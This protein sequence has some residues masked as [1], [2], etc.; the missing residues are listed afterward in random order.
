VGCHPTG[1][2][3]LDPAYTAVLAAAVTVSAAKANRFALLILGVTGAVLSRSWV[4]LPAAIGAALAVQIAFPGRFSRRLES[5]VRPVVGTLAIQS[6]LRWPSVGFHGLTALITG[7][8]VGLVLVTA[9]AGTERRARRLLVGA[10]AAV[11]LLAGVFSALVGL[12]AMMAKT[13]VDNGIAQARKALSA[14]SSGDSSVGSAELAAS[15]GDLRSAHA[16][17]SSWWTLGGLLVPG[18]AQQRRAMVDATASA[19]ALTRAA[20][21]EA[22]SL[23]Y[24]QLRFRHGQIDLTALRN[25]ASPLTDLD[26]QLSV[27][28]RSLA[29]STS[30]W[31]IPPISRDLR[32][33]I[34]EVSRAKS[35]ADLGVLAARDGPGIL[36]GN[37]PRH[38]L[39]VF[40]TPAETRGLGGFI[41]AYGEITASNGRLTLGHAG[42]AQGL[43]AALSGDPPS[44]RGLNQ[45][46]ARYGAFKPQLFFQDLTYSPDFPSDE[47]AISESYSHVTGE[48]IDGV[49]ALDPDA[50]AALLRFTGSIRVGGLPEPLNSADAANVLLRQQY[51]IYPNSRAQGGRHDLL[52]TAL[53]TAFT[54]LSKIS[55]PNPRTLANSLSP[56]VHEGRLLFWS[57]HTSDQPLLRRLGIDGTFPQPGHGSDLLALTF[58]NSANNKIDSYMTAGASDDVTYDPDTGAVNSTVTLKLSNSA[59][60]SGLPDYVIGSYRGSKLP[61]GTNYT[62]FSLYTPLTLGDASV[63]G[64]P[65]YFSP[66][67]PELGVGAYSTWVAIPARSTVIV[68]I[69]LSGNVGRRSSYSLEVRLQPLA[70][71]PTLSV[72]MASPKGWSPSSPRRWSASSQEV[73]NHRW[74]FHRS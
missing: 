63:D 3:V 47:L 65:L 25:L 16:K 61:P 54:R 64:K 37:G 17:T 70:T 59:P 53:K 56:M 34:Q 60:N 23:N 26:A 72:D 51:I 6:M 57:T 27:A 10:S 66:V 39:V 19:A 33:F 14:V 36:G 48:Q 21:S 42:S 44:F 9:I 62:W 55:L 18:V 28:Q 20:G 41:G 12:S 45:W 29:R 68:T 69:Q 38:Y 46:V 74:T 8:T 49:L 13:P 1:N 50:L 73:Q 52:I 71:E 31:L 30:Q 35:G 40:V 58:S 67:V 43:N 7:L 11:V 15:A 5:V 2:S 4:L 32:K 22:G 24:T